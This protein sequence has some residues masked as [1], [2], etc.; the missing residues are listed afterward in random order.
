MKTNSFY[1]QVVERENEWRESLADLLV[2]DAKDWYPTALLTAGI[3]FF[4]LWSIFCYMLGLYIG[5]M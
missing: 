5:G 3:V 4:L 2:E 1:G